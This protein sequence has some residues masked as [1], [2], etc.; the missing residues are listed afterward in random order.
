M[1]KKV[2][3]ML[4]IMAMVVTAISGCSSEDDGAEESG[5]ETQESGDEDQGETVSAEAPDAYTMAGPFPE[6]GLTGFDI[7]TRAINLTMDA[8]N[9]TFVNNAADMTADGTITF[10]ESEIAAGVEGMIICPP[11][12]SILPTITTLCE[13]A[14]V[15]W[16]IS[17]RSIE[18][19]EIKELVEASP[20]YVGNCYEDEESTEYQVGAWMGEQGYEKIAIISQAKGDTTCDAREVGLLRACEEYGIEI[21]AESRGLSQTSDATSATESFLS[22]NTDLDAILY[23]GTAV[24]N[25]H[26]ATVKAIRDAGREEVK[27]LTIDFPDEIEANFESGIQVYATGVSTMGY[28]PLITIIKVI[29]AIAGT[30]LDNSGA[31]TSNYIEMFEI[32]T[33]EDAAAYAATIEVED[34][35]IYD[36]EF[37][38]QNLFKWNNPDLDEESL[39][40]IID[41]YSPLD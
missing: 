27:M 24:T 31:P 15:Y 13:E 1:K 14:G 41:E 21:V 12:D 28:D 40:Q 38:E 37:I 17:M 19:E 9:G 36:Q 5:T 4:L 8:S 25:A 23:V 20:Y 6:T 18:D 22:A 29:N 30:P 33:T 3:S 26:E 7:L 32:T 2:I 11:T 16:G 34:F 10:V 39:Q 35:T